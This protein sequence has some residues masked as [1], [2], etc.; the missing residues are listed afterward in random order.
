MNKIIKLF[1]LMGVIWGFLGFI[2][3]LIF[4]LIRLSDIAIDSFKY[5]YNFYHWVAVIINSLFMAYSEGYKGFQKSF[6]PRLAARLKYL[7]QKGNPIELILAPLFC[8]SFFNAPKKRIFIS[9]SLTILIISFVIFFHQLPQPWRGILD[10]GVL[11][12]LTWGLVV[13]CYFFIQAFKSND[14]L[15]DPEIKYP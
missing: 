5:D 8:M 10:I 12:G 2:F 14:F 6:S 4:A 3:L 7:Y 11:I 15:I 1:H 13:S 9:L